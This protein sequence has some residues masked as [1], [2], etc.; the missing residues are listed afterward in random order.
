[1]MSDEASPAL[2]TLIVDD[3]P[4]AVERMMTL[5]QALD[6]VALVGTAT[7]GRMAAELVTA[8]RPDLLLLD[9]AMPEMDGMS[10][11]HQIAAMPGK[12][13]AII[14]VTAFDAFAVEAFDLPAADYLLKPVAAERLARAI[15]RV[16]AT[17]AV[18]PAP[19][20]TTTSDHASDYAEEFWVPHKSELVR[21]AAA[22]ID[23]VDAERDYMRLHVGARSFLIHQ[24]IAT[25][26]ARLDPARFIRLHRSTIVRRDRI[27]GFGHDRAGAWHAVLL[28]GEQVRIGRTYQ[29]AAKAMAGKLRV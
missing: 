22:D 20:P 12:R 9:I 2:R 3:E 18:A 19:A 14:F 27:T 10:L 13:P 25:L 23:R 15:G 4:L 29:A 6:G 24:T 8:L 5:C 21:I 7:N 11:A 16:Q 28:D 17:R 1:M 26:E